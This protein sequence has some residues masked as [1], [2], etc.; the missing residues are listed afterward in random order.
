MVADDGP[1][2]PVKERE[3]VLRRFYRL[4][5]SRTTPGNGLGLAL[6]SAI[7][8]LHDAKLELEDGGPGLQVRVVFPI[9][10]G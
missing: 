3:N 7:A 10:S 6:A 8:G 1:G 2:I 5:R 9:V 4:A